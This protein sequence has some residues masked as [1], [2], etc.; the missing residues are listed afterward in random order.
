MRESRDRFI[1][2]FVRTNF[3]QLLRV[4]SLSRSR[5]LRSELS[6]MRNYLHWLTLIFAR[7]RLIRR[8]N[9]F[10]VIIFF[11]FF[12]LS[13]SASF[14]F[15]VVEPAACFSTNGRKDTSSTRRLLVDSRAELISLTRFTLFGSTQRRR[16]F[17]EQR[18]ASKITSFKVNSKGG[19]GYWYTCARSMMTSIV[20]IEGRDI[21]GV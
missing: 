19:D 2:R 11:S 14:S 1:P 4:I 18:I 9:T 6:F 7:R 20:E 17:T 8:V 15:S 21:T 3:V 10:A 12:F 13:F 5:S 16:P